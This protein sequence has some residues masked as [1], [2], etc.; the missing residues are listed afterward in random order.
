MKTL[1][2]VLGWIDLVV[3]VFCGLGTFYDHKPDIGG[4]FLV[5]GFGGWVT[6]LTISKVL[7]LLE[8]IADQTKPTDKTQQVTEEPASWSSPNWVNQQQ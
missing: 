8:R 1:L 6:L 3:C 4:M 7:E 5:A 2:K